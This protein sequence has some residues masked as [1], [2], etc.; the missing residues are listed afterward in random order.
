MKIVKTQR[1]ITKSMKTRVIVHVFCTSSHV[2]K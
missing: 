2:I 1:A